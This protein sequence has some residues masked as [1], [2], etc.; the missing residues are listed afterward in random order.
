MAF[1]NADVHRVT[2]Q[3]PLSFTVKSR[4]LSLFR[5][6]ACIDGTAG[7]KQVLL[8]PM[9]VLWRRLPGDH[10]SCIQHSCLP[11]VSVQETDVDIGS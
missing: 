2:D 4:R 6:M 8:K 7:A 3:P 1:T 5:H 9:P 10:V 11:V